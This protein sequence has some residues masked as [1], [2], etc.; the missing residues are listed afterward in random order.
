VAATRDP[1]RSRLTVSV[2]N[3][4]PVQAL[5]T[6]VRLLDA[7]ATGVMTGHEVNGDGPQAVNSFA[8]PDAVTVRRLKHEVTGGHIDVTF[9]P[10]S[11]TVLEVNLL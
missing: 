1:E 10:H 2:V 9:A 5:P 8:H 7:E 6:R 4:D 11:F 3:R